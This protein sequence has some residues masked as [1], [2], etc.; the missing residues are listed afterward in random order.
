MAEAA[1]K[2][3][4][5]IL[6]SGLS[7][8]QQGGGA[9][10][11]GIE[12]ARHLDPDDFEPIIC[13][14][15]RRNLPAETRWAD[16]LRTAG[17]ETFYAVTRDQR[18]T[19]WRYILGLR[20]ISAHL[21]GRPPVIIHSH[22]QLGTI[23]ALVLR[24]MLGARATLRTAHGTVA[25]EW[26]NRWPGRV[27]RLLFT[28]WLF[29]IGLDA[30]VGV[31]RAIVADMNTRPG[32]R[33]WRK[34]MYLIYN[35]IPALP[36][37]E[38]GT[39]EAARI[40]LGLS[41]DDLVIGS[42]GRLSEQKGYTYLLRALTTI[43]TKWPAARVILIGDGELRGALEAEAA[44]LGVAHAITFVGA[45]ADAGAL[46]PALDLFVLPSLWEGLPTVVLESMASGVPVV[47][48]DIP[49]TCDLVQEGVT[50]WLAPP[51]DPSG[52]SQAILRAL[53]D[54]IQRVAIARHAAEQVVPR[55]TMDA[56]ARQYAELYRQLSCKHGR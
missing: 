32:A 51:A 27:C 50:G 56:I 16:V 24:M 46:Y 4:V 26:E 12:L 53:D 8:G 36:L 6:I 55:Y 37:R 35:G 39:R 18:F 52:L 5:L 22:F 2:V 31:S 11:F 44:A 7:I 14:F 54:P 43:L 17:V 3:R 47:A 49:G 9:E 30:E 41:A 28:R 33:L 10:R 19:P 23:A 38:T 21:R 45:R 13:A 34:P 15:W 1:K 42:V 48:T 20:T 40:A 25:R 29:P